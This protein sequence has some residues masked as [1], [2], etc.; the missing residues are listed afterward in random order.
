M[1]DVL[2]IKSNCLLRPEELSSIRTSLM[3]QKDEGVIV[4]PYGFDVIIVPDDIEINILNKEKR[5]E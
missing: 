1:D 2:V 4:I 3:C 5:N